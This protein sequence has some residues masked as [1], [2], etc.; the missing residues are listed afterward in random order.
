[1]RI[2][3]PQGCEAPRE[4][5]KLEALVPLGLTGGVGGAV[6]ETAATHTWE[7]RAA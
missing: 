7:K 6:I 4:R 5:A 2:L 3:K 1:M